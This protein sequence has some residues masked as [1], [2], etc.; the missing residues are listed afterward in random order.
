VTPGAVDEILVGGQGDHAVGG[1]NG[2]GARGTSGF[3]A[4]GGGGGA[5]DVRSGACAATSSCDAGAR[6]IVAGGGGGGGNLAGA[7]SGFGGAGG[8]TTAGAGAGAGGGSGANGSFGSGGGGGGSGY[9]DP[10]LVSSGTMHTAVS[11]VNGQVTISY[12]FAA[13]S[14]SPTGGVSFPGTQSRQTLSGPLTVTVTNSGDAPLQISSLTFAG[15]DPEDFLISYN[16]RM[17]QVAAGASC[18]LGV[19]F[20]PRGKARAPRHCKS[21]ATTPTAPRA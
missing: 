4:N 3:N 21:P 16:G 7:D 10:Y 12:T 14:Y 2:G 11:S 19:S 13:P 9:I 8:G 6:I 15:S 17:A 5:S 18:K 1:F 20:A